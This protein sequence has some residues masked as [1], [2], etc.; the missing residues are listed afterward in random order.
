MSRW[1]ISVDECDR[2]LDHMVA[3]G[4]LCYVRIAGAKAPKASNIGELSKYRWGRALRM[5]KSIVVFQDPW[6]RHVTFRAYKDY[7]I[8]TLPEGLPQADR[9]LVM[10]S[11]KCIPDDF[12]CCVAIMQ[13]HGET[14]GEGVGVGDAYTALLIRDSR[15]RHWVSQ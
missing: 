13:V 7:E 6:K 12:I 15:G 3:P 10:A 11:E 2:R 5:E 9:L 8:V 1:N 4:T 14:V